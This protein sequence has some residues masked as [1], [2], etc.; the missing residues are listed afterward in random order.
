MRGLVVI[1]TR[2]QGAWNFFYLVCQQIIKFRRCYAR[3]LEEKIDKAIVKSNYFAR[4]PHIL[5]FHKQSLICC[6]H[7]ILGEKTEIFVNLKKIKL[8][9]FQPSFQHQTVV[10]L[11]SSVIHI[12]HLVSAVVQ[13]LNSNLKLIKKHVKIYP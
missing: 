6:K 2:S 9:S 13:I 1:S 4:P 5:K 7:R 11:Q 3:P 10:K 8:P 12:S